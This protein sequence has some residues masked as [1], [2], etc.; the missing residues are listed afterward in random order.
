MIIASGSFKGWSV[1]NFFKT[2]NEVLGGCN[3]TYTPAQEDEV[4]RAIN[5]NYLMHGKMM[6][7]NGYLM[8]P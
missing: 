1:M 5:D 7:D 8:C 6:M 3:T 2:A 4:A